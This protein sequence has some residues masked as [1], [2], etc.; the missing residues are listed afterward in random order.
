[1]EH[2]AAQIRGVEAEVAAR[3]AALERLSK[4]EETELSVRVKRQRETIKRQREQLGAAVAA[5]KGASEA[6]A[7]AARAHVASIERSAAAASEELVLL[8]K[9]QHFPGFASDMVVGVTVAESSNQRLT[10]GLRVI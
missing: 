6:E 1:M 2:I 8:L 3:C 7:A 10:P 4:A 9:K 5:A